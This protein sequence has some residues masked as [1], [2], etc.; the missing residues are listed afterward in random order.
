[1]SGTNCH[2]CLRP[3]RPSTWQS[4]AK[5]SFPDGGAANQ[6]RRGGRGARPTSGLARMVSQTAGSSPGAA[7]C[8]PRT[9]TDFVFSAPKRFARLLTVCRERKVV[10]GPGIAATSGDPAGIGPEML[11]RGAAAKGELL[12]GAGATHPSVLKQLDLNRL[13]SPARLRRSASR[14]SGPQG[15]TGQL[16]TSLASGSRARRAWSRRLILPSCLQRESRRLQEG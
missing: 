7:I 13:A 14:S 8:F 1:V 4:R 12:A 15:T 6:A 9:M 3:L 5:T 2:P 11:A 16:S 10:G